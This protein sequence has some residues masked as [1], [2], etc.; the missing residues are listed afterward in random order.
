M[1]SPRFLSFALAVCASLFIALPPALGADLRHTPDE[2]I[3]KFKASA[4]ATQKSAILADLHAADVKDLTRIQAKLERIS[5]ISVTDAVTRYS[6]SDAVEFIEP[7]Y[8]VSAEEVPNDPRFPDLWGLQN[9]GQTGG[10]AGADISAVS[11]W[12]VFTGS[13]NVVVGIID[14]GVDYLHPDLASNIYVNVNEIPSNGIDDDHNGFIDDVHGWDFRNNDNDP[15]DDAGHG[16][17]VAGTIGAVGNNGIGVAGVNWKVRIMPL[18]FLGAD[19]FGTT[20]D[21]VSCVEYATMM[22]VRLTS[23]SWGGG[24]FSEALR[25]AIA[26]AGAAG[27]L[28]VAA[29]GNSGTDNDLVPHYPSSYGEPNIVAVAA[30]DDHDRLAGFSCFGATSVDL[31]APGVHILSTIPGGSY[32]YLDGTSMATPHVSGTLALIFGRFPAVSGAD[33]VRL[34]FAGVDPIPSLA[35]KMVTGGRLNAFNVLAEPDSLPPAAIADLTVAAENGNWIQ[36]TWT[37]TGD[38]GLAGTASRYEVRYATFPINAINFNTA[39][40]AANPPDPAA[41]G[42]PEEMQVQGLAFNTAYYF[43]IKAFDEFGNASP[44]S[45]V[46]T[47]TTIGPPDI[48]YS[49]TSFSENLFS[50]GS[51]TQTLTLENHGA[52]DLVFDLSVAAG[53]S[54]GAVIQRV[55]SNSQTRIPNTQAIPPRAES[56]YDAG[57][58]PTFT[59]GVVA[60]PETA[61]TSGGL[62]VL[63]LQSGADVAEIRSQL[64]GFSDIGAVDVFDAGSG[65]PTLDD[66][67]P[68]HAVIVIL[69]LP[70]ASPAATGDVLADYADAGGGVVLTL[71]SFIAGW[72]VEGRF[73]SGGYYPFNLGTGP[74]GASSLGAFDHTHPIMEGVT[75]AA[76]DL[77]G[78]VSTAPGAALIAQWANS[79]PFVATQGNNI[80]GV[81]IFVGSAGHWA[82]DVPLVLRNA[83]LWSGHAVAWLSGNPKSGV[84]PGGG[85]IGVVVSFDATGLNGGRYDAVMEVNS[86]DPDEATVGVPAHLSVT[87]APDITLSGSVLEFGSVFLGGAQTRNLMVTNVGT[88]LLNVSSITANSPDF[89]ASLSSLSLAPGASQVV[90]VM[91]RPSAVGA[92]TGTLTVASNDPDEGSLSVALSGEGLLPPDI[93]VSPAS[94]SED[95]FSGETSTQ[96]LT[97]SNTGAS[98]LDFLVNVRG[99]VA[100]AVSVP[101]AGLSGTDPEAS[102]NP[103]PPQGS[104]PPEGAGEFIG[105]VG[106]FQAL[107]ASPVPLTCVVADPV[108]GVLYGQANE[109][110]GFYRYRAATDTWETLASAPLAS[111]NNGGAALLNNKIYTSYTGNGSQLGVYDIATNTWTTR[112]NPLGSGTGNIASDGTRY[113][114][115]VASTSFLRLDPVTSASTGLSAPPFSFQPWGGLRHLNGVLYGHQGNGTTGFARY[116]IA[117]NTWTA[118]A[119]LPSGGVLGADI[120]P[121]AREYY[122]YGSYG[123]A[124]LYRYSIDSGMWSVSTVPFFA[125]NDGGLGWL[126]SPGGVYFVQGQGGTGLARLVTSVPFLTVDPSAGTVPAS[127]TLTLNAHFNATGL[128]GGSYDAVIEVSSNDPD[129]PTVGVPA[130]LSVTG[131]PDIA[132]SGE[133]VTLES[134]QTY[135]GS[136]ASTA[137]LFPITIPPSGGGTLEL[138]AEGDYGDLTESATAR[139]EG[140]FVGLVGAV[141]S[142]C[143]PASGS[144][145]VSAALLSAL[146]A[147]GTVGVVVQNSTDVNDFCSP[148]RHTVRLRYAGPADMLAFGPVFIGGS[149]TRNLAVTNAGT[150]LLSVS[151]ITVDSP[152]FTVSL[153]SLSL[154]PGASQVVEVTFRPSVVGARTGTLTVASNDPDEGS[155]RVALSGEGLV[156][157]DI[158]VSPASLSENL[159]S[160][161]TSTKVLTVSNTGGSALDFLVNVRA[162]V[163]GAVSVPFAGL[164]A[165]AP[166]ASNNPPPNQGANL[167]ERVVEFIG[168]AGD[169]Q[170]LHASPVPLTCVVAD[171]VAGVLYGQANEGTAFYRYRAATDTWETLA[172]APLASGNNGGA[173]LLNNKIY[174]SYTENSTQLGIYDIGTNTWT[175][176][177]NP[178][179]SG[180]GNI[181]SDGTRYLYLVVR[182]IFVRLDPATSSTTSLSSPPFFFE[183]WGGLRH[184]NGV[185]YGHQGNGTTGFAR[186]DIATNVWTVLPSLPSGG[187][188]GADINPLAR[189]YYAYGSYGET[190]LYRYSIDSGMWSVSTVPF[191]PVDDGGLGWLP[192]PVGLY[193]VEGEGG[194]GLARLVTSVPFLTVDPSAGTVPPSGTL[195]LNAHFN[196]AGLN[197]GSYDAVIDVSSNDPDEPTVG[198]PAHLSVTGAPDIA[199]S[200]NAL[201]FGS[202]YIG[203]SQTRNLVVTNAGTDL[204]NVSSITANSPDFTASLSS[205]SLAPGASQVVGVMFRPLTPGART[206]TLTVASNDPDEGSLGV[207]LSG[208]GLVPPDIGISPASLS[209]NLFSG[210]TSTQALTVSNTGASAL[211]FLVNVRGEVAGAVSVPF[212]GLSATDPGA[213]NNPA[214][215]PGESPPEAAAEFIGA[216][217]DFQALHASPVPLTCVVADP[218]AGVLYGQANNGTGFY[219]Y[220]AATDTWETLASVPLA[221]GNNGGAALLN[222]KIYTSYTGNGSQLGVYDIATNTW[223]TRSNPLGNGTGN[224]A[225]DGTRYLYLVVN[226]S[227]VRLDPVTSASTGLS[228]PPFS[229]QPWGGL[230]HLNG[231]LYGHQGNGFTGFARYDVATNAWTALASLPSGGVLGADIHPLAR[232]YYAYGSYGGTNL[233]RYSIDSGM[234]SVSTVPFF[235]LNDGGLGWLPSPG[236]VYFVQGEVGTGLAR[237]VTSVPFLTVDPSAG[238]VPASGTLTLN[239]H[240]NA[241]G[242]NGGSY[243]AVIEVSSNDPDE[244]TVAVPA[245]LSVTGAPLLSLTPSSLDFG[246]LFVGLTREL[247][248]VAKNLGTDVLSV[249]SVVPGLSDYTY[250]GSGFILNPGQSQTVP[251]RFQPLAGGDRSTTLTFSSNDPHSPRA[252]PLIGAGVVPPTIV[253]T[254]ASLVGAAMPGGKKTK[255]LSICNTG[256]TN[257]DFTIGSPTPPPP[258]PSGAKVAVH[259]QSPAAKVSQTC[260]AP[261]DGGTAPTHI[262]C[263]E[264][265]TQASTLIG[266]DVYVVVA[267]VEDTGVRG[268]SL[269]IAYD[270]IAGHGVQVGRWTFCGDLQ[271]P[272]DTWPA[273]GSG[274]IMTWVD[275]QSHTIDPDGIHAIAGAFYV[276]AYASD[277]F[278]ITENNAVGSPGLKY[279]NCVGAEVDIPV[280][281]AGAVRFSPGGVQPGFNPC[282]GGVLVY[283]GGNLA[284][285]AEDHR[286]GFP[287]LDGIG[288]PDHHG[289]RWVDSDEPGG[290]AFHWVEIADVGTQVPVQGDDA[291]SGPLPIGFRFPFY[292]NTFDHFT[293]CTNGFI[294]FTSTSTAFTNQ[295]LP[296]DTAPENL[297]APCWD[298]LYMSSRKAYYYN[299][300]SSLFIEFQDVYRL[301]GEGP[302]TFEVVLSPDG[303]I[304]YQY[305][306]LRGVLPS[307]TVGIQNGTKDD[308]LTVA[309]NTSYLHD[310]LAVRFSGRPAWL[311][312]DPLSGTVP[313]SQCLDLQ[314]IMDATTLVADDYTSSIIISSND[315]FNPSLSRDVL[316]HVGTVDAAYADVD[317]NS[318][319][320][321]S[322]G[323]WI[324]A[325][326][327]LP[328]GFSPAEIVLETVRALGTVPA[329]T[330][331]NVIGDFNAN[332]IPD[333]TLKFDRGVCIAALPPEADSALVVITGEIRDRSYFVARDNIRILRPHLRTLNGGGSFIKGTF[334]EIAWDIPSGWVPQYADLF[335]SPDNGVTWTPLASGVTGQRQVW[336]IPDA[337]TEA[338]RVSVRVYGQYGLMGI[339]T[340]DQ[341]FTITNSVTGVA[342]ELP[343]AT[344]LLQNVPNPFSESTVIHF[345]LLKDDDVAIHVYDVNGRVVRELVAGPMPAGRHEVA[346]DGRS[347]SGVKVASGLYL[348]RMETGEYTEGKRMFLLH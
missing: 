147:D 314:V 135:V 195:T 102:N 203:G 82:G 117:T 11:A 220:R 268:L 276:Y 277:T 340:S 164:S 44:I 168:A 174:T 49:P 144:F 169:F 271:F 328:T 19:G 237:L 51:A 101:F 57:A 47:G 219:R 280:T 137:H 22:G 159:F 88:D 186:Y 68:Y 197:G 58:V 279:A 151:S 296:A 2:V 17:H 322:N 65:S 56:A 308:G 311:T 189:E 167:P 337:L 24:G 259:V 45:N 86:N 29:A 92:R 48:A 301:S 212:A 27:I 320:P 76:G 155:L 345:N 273:S 127:G 226:M 84:I 50:G 55:V 295:P 136:G 1:F 33:A 148:N 100:G 333:R 46:P 179:G 270:P 269:G 319:N 125:L 300:A 289:Y 132:I 245:H 282:V 13:P 94:L 67:L 205:L 285:G 83:A 323:R 330:S 216:V 123:G 255:T 30:T 138:I 173:A 130:H 7:N 200:G 157:P 281:A 122:A 64:E 326:A 133:E 199:L 81:N 162:E 315:P 36:L 250:L 166:R 41:S 299:N 241:T 87:G 78:A 275:C 307:A 334:V 310:N 342:E 146:A 60:T 172:S 18:K 73:L 21:A 238:T 312:I 346:W 211:D 126:P 196:A 185:L 230:R 214:P 256:G 294:S 206:G 129:E 176:R 265:V 128:N 80:V 111:G 335:Y 3:I 243:D 156:P 303:S 12:D 109:G 20:A 54:T 249:S 10:I 53:D 115:L 232:E 257:L 246:E 309:F 291:N 222:D 158:G 171:P 209:E 339:D 263:S 236:G 154:A 254:P 161:E 178:L 231:V 153:S 16:T 264:Y 121:L 5:G 120:N 139:A 71:A 336:R 134:V 14:T 85:S 253:A 239:A 284:K 114:Y 72:Q 143:V 324:T 348:Y 91:F 77:L 313:P 131:A 180:T 140:T 93:G 316:F 8:I 208:E 297:I 108:V 318:L 119:S 327:E 344:V 198:V 142:D 215:D 70:V 288:G 267:G 305:L 235:A 283:G 347:S 228:A 202:V 28:F 43:A 59:T 66:L 177:S 188:L 32:A 95:L 227:F 190:N 286:I 9:T 293:V 261:E 97:V 260:R 23:N 113:L 233:Y 39:G 244:P 317:P 63:L 193:F 325:S 224:I 242:L 181:A 61:A 152:D 124:N 213:S 251:I 170:A 26:D 89:T 338:A 274:N 116:D 38:D 278:R 248:V 229:F 194:T 191:F 69:N 183:P 160:G 105:A 35:G 34:L 42:S 6:D 90:E 343:S 15:M 223:T 272:S 184:L 141:G 287:V 266:R 145:P 112:S 110:T 321:G 262:P 98:A 4:T 201:E 104:D 106:D 31:A 103:P 62:R 258:P 118:L 52:G 175:T 74:I 304:L 247:G 217:G 234:W 40:L 75:T 341:P 96:V 298:D 332:G 187:V 302:Y 25:Q 204:L 290:P 150:D 165:T 149:Q 329:D 221:S 331:F 99:E 306:Y 182:T 225:S 37:A 218:V 292:G 252:F 79:Q 192:S 207:A 163:A 107:H 210:E 240:F